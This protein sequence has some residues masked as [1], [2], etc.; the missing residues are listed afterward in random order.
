MQIASK[1]IYHMWIM[2]LSMCIN[3]NAYVLMKN[4]RVTNSSGNMW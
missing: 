2:R 1:T 4:S 3:R